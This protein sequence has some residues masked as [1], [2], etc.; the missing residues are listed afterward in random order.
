MGGKVEN[1]LSVTEKMI[2]SKFFFILEF[3]IEDRSL[4]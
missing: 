4:R 3:K 1:T 2:N